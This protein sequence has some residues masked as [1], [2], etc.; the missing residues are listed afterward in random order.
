MLNYASIAVED[1]MLNTPPCWPIYMCGL[2]FAHMLANGGL[3]SMEEAN[4]KVSAK[5]CRPGVNCGRACSL[6]TPHQVSDHLSSKLPL[7]LGLVLSAQKARVLYEAI[8]GSGG[9]F[10]SPVEPAARSLMN[11]P[12]TIPSNAD[13]E[14]K[15]V[16]EADARSMVR[17]YC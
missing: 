13:L 16:A 12:F 14:K 3:K 1:S 9:F 6:G 4:E 10:A 7:W 11:V 2:V 17:G 8:E 5:C 15:F